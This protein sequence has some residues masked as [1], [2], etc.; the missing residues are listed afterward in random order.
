MVSL[1][2]RYSVPSLPS[3]IGPVTGPKIPPVD[4][5]SPCP[6]SSEVPIG[7][8]FFPSTPCV[9]GR[10]QSVLVSRTLPTRPRS[11]V[12][13]ESRFSESNVRPSTV[14]IPGVRTSIPHGS[15]VPVP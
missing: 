2:S 13:P 3:V 6:L 15:P 14:G 9:G 5:L 10:G 11:S 8:L 4:S 7:V 12:F 1:S